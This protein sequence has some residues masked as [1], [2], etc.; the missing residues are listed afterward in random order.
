[1][2][3]DIPLPYQLHLSAHEKKKKLEVVNHASIIKRRQWSG[4]SYAISVSTVGL[5]SSVYH[6]NAFT[7]IIS[8]EC[9]ARIYIQNNDSRLLSHEL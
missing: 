8:V 1:M 7:L 6:S 5:L 9:T 2:V 3:T 4:L